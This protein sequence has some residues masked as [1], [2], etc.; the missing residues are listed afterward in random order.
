MKIYIEA[1]YKDDT[2]KLGNLDGQGI[3]RAKNYKR[4]NHYK[5]LSSFPTLNNC[6]KYYKL[7]TEYG[8]TLE[9]VQNKTFP[10]TT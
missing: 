7:V 5:M 10:F 9:I 2:Q 4:T 6:V 1:Y 3:I 8:L